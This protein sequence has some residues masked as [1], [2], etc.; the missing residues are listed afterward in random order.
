VI[1]NKIESNHTDLAATNYWT[2]LQSNN[3][4]TDKETKEANN[5]NNTSTKE[6][7]KTN[8]WERRLAR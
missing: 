7:P 8:K 1:S 5:I 6:I 2:P 4:E 3:V